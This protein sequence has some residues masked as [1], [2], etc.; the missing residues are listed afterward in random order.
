MRIKGKQSKKKNTGKMPRSGSTGNTGRMSH[1]GSTGKMPHS[2]STGKM[3]RTGNTGKITPFTGKV[4]RVEFGKPKTPMEGLSVIQKIR[5]TAVAVI[6]LLLAG[7]AFFLIDGFKIRNVRVEGSTHYTQ[8]QIRNMVITDKFSENSLYLKYKL[9]AKKIENIPFVEHMDVVIEDRTS[10]KIIVYEKAVAGY[11]MYLENRMYFDKDGIV[12]ESSKDV[13]PGIPEISGLD[14]DHVILHEPLPV[15][16]PRIFKEI[17]SITQ[18]LNKNKL[19]AD[20]IYFDYMGDITL[21]FGDIRV[22]LGNGDYLDERV[23]HL[24]AILEK[25]NPM[26]FKGKLHMESFTVAN[27]RTSFEIDE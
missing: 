25:A 27:P 3:P 10:I 9:K 20:K 24:S 14:F 7:G 1:S 21:Y 26:G 16:D 22:A 6:V 13:V 17:L 12:V 19:D 18:L 4:Q 8:D 15:D 5:I 11:V 23:T 2:G